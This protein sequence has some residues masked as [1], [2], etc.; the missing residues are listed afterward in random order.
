MWLCSLKQPYIG[1]P[2]LLDISWLWGVLWHYGPCFMKL[3][4]PKQGWIWDG[5]WIKGSPAMDILITSF[6]HQKSDNQNSLSEEDTNLHILK[7]TSNS[8][9]GTSAKWYILWSTRV[10]ILWKDGALNKSMDCRLV[11]ST[12]HETSRVF[13][14]TAGQSDERWETVIKETP[15]KYTYLREMFRRHREF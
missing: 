7:T 4:K 12:K 1:G 15:H 2:S 9:S 5:N 8:V 6:P 10:A 14:T 13:D 11:C 3:C